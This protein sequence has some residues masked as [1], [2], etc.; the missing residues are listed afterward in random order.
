M[1][2]AFTYLHQ[3]N[4]YLMCDYQNRAYNTARIIMIIYAL[5]LNTESVLNKG[6]AN[7]DAR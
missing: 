1:Q 7:G 4:Q 5:M 6:S 2:N 3:L